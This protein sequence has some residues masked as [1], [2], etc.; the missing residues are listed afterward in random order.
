VTRAETRKLYERDRNKVES[1]RFVC[2]AWVC[3]ARNS[4]RCS[5]A[6]I[7]N[8]KFELFYIKRDGHLSLVK[9]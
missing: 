3:L 4:K 7:S 8:T 9:N 6:R 2:G 5:P 1:S